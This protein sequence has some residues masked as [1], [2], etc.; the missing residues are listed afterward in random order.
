MEYHGVCPAPPLSQ[1]VLLLLGF[2]VCGGGQEEGLPCGGLVLALQ[3]ED[4]AL[5]LPMVL[6]MGQDVR[7]NVCDE[8]SRLL[9]SGWWSVKKNPF[10]H[11]SIGFLHPK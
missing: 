4:D 7:R 6:M 5:I 3:I 8:E 11:I 1:T 10:I 9:P 2:V